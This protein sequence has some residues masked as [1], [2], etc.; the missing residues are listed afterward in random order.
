MRASGLQLLRLKLCAIAACLALLAL[1]A[2]G[3]NVPVFRYALEAWTPANYEMFVFHRGKLSDADSKLIDALRKNSEDEKAPVNITFTAVDV[4][5]KMD[6]R[7]QKIWADQKDA[8]LP[9]AVLAYPDSSDSFWSGTLNADVLTQIAPSPARTEIAKRITGGDSVVF[10]LLESGKKD[11]DSAA[12]SLLTKELAGLQAT[13]KLPKQD[14]EDDEI[15]PRRRRLDIPLK[16]KFSILKIARSDTK[17]KVFIDL[18]MK[19]DAKLSA[20]QPVIFP[21]FGRGRLLCALTGS[22]ISVPSLTECATFLSGACSCQVKDL[23][24]GV[25][26]LMNVNWD[27]LLDEAVTQA[28]KNPEKKETQPAAENPPAPEKKPAEVIVT[29][30]TQPAIN[31]A[32]EKGS[33]TNKL[34]W[35]AAAAAAALLVFIGARSLK[36]GN[37]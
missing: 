11:A 35:G 21:V 5:E 24:P 36:T 10:V 14:D 26:L 12:E 15:V 28:A 29:S 16:L 3:C 2:F 7:A 37:G 27:T 18:L 19:T 9:R 31:H 34:L 6:E 17:E 20:A 32:V 33:E 22:T 23:N 13:M 4:S 8:A 1:P 30:P 25:D